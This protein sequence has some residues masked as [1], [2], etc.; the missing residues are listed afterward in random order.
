ML[1]ISTH[2][3]D[4]DAQTMRS[5]GGYISGTVQDLWHQ[6]GV[7]MEHVERC[8]ASERQALTPTAQA[9]PPLP[10]QVRRYALQCIAAIM[11]HEGMSQENW[12][13]AVSLLDTYLLKVA[14]SI[15]M[16]PVSCICVVRLVAKLNS[17]EFLPRKLS[18]NCLAFASKIAHDMTTAGVEAPDITEDVFNSHEQVI[19]HAVS[20]KI[21][22]MT[23][24][25]WISMFSVR[26]DILTK[27]GY[28]Q[29]MV[30]AVV[31]ARMLVMRESASLQFSHHNLALGVFSL[32]LVMARLI[33]FG[34]LSPPAI[35]PAGTNA[36][37][38]QSTLMNKELFWMIGSLETV[39]CCELQ[40][41]Q[42]AAQIVMQALPAVLTQQLFAV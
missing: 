27:N 33:P 41:L 31:M 15:P 4:G 39:T 42:Q 18:M 40:D 5:G 19:G 32:S 10:G 34:L 25:R 35:S 22:L 2:R 8:K 38:L 20:W 21:D 3:P 30:E 29:T 1:P 28:Q 24:E 9:G 23:V 7:S 36:A 12:F 14:G 17:A 26:F 13:Q 11:Q 6:H 37:F 16:L